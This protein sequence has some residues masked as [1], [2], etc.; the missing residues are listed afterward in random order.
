[1]ANNFGLLGESH[2]L[3][4]FWHNLGRFR[5]SGGPS[6]CQTLSSSDLAVGPRRRQPYRPHSRGKVE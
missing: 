6:E 5:L 1:M 2:K 4:L 3:G